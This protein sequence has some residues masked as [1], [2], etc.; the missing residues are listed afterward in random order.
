[1]GEHNDYMGNIVHPAASPMAYFSHQINEKWTAGLSMNTPY[2]MITKYG[3]DWSGR[4][5]GTLSKIISAT[6]TPMVAY[7]ANDKL[8]FG[9]GLQIQYRLLFY[10]EFD[11]G[12]RYQNEYLL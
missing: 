3:D 12:I 10:G 9:A 2:G 11:C 1:M 5:H 8:S 4:F 6:F 7:K